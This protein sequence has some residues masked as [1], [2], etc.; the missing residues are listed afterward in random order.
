MNILLENS[1]HLEYYG[2][3]TDIFNVL[4]GI[5]EKYDWYISDIE[6]NCK[7]PDEINKSQVFIEGNKLKKL[8]YEN[9]IQF[10][11]AVFS[12]LPKGIRPLVKEIPFAD[13]NPAFWE[14][15]PKPQLNGAAFEIVCWD[16]SLFLLIGVSDIIAKSFMSKYSDAVDLDKYNKNKG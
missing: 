10:V 5:C 6:T 4:D 16:T 15:S 1:K 14:G 8:V 11:W 7:P 12:A 3:M 2:F 13:G 9:E